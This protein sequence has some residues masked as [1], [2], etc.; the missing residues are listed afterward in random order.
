M[1]LPDI[2]GVQLTGQRQKRHHPTDIALALTEFLRK[3][4]VVGAYVEF[5]GVGADSL[6]IGDRATISEYVPRVRCDGRAV[7]HRP[8]N[9]RLPAPDRPQ[10]LSW[11]KPT[12]NRRPVGRHAA[13]GAVRARAVA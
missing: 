2:V 12:P 7:L 4:K 5:F 10:A 6:S 11:W 3:E 9:H 13:R 1:R 8:A